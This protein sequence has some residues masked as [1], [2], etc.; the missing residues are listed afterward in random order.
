MERITGAHGCTVIK[1]N[2]VTDY[3]LSCYFHST[4]I[5]LFYYTFK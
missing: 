1:T 4:S 5:H 2:M 3:I